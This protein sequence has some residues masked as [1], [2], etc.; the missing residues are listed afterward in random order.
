[1]VTLN[2]SHIWRIEA[3]FGPLCPLKFEKTAIQG[4]GASCD[5]KCAWKLGNGRCAI[6]QIAINLSEKKK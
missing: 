3:M 4:P 2:E 6:A 1:M 5:D